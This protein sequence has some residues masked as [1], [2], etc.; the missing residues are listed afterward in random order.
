MECL[1]DCPNTD[2]TKPA[3]NTP[4]FHAVDK[5]CTADVPASTDAKKN[6]DCMPVLAGSTVNTTT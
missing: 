3:V 4:G 2:T 6:N 5:K 1:A